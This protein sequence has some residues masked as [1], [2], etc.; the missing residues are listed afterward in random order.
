[1]MVMSKILKKK[2]SK[3]DE[4]PEENRK[5]IDMLDN[6]GSCVSKENLEDITAF[7]KG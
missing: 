5:I 4:I 2:L 7:I 1:M 3:G 6:G